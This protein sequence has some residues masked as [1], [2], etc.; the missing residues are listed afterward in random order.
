MLDRYSS[1][2]LAM[3]GQGLGV[4]SLRKYACLN[5]RCP[6]AFKRCPCEVLTI[7]ASTVQTPSFPRQA[8]QLLTAP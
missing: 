4:L 6:L 2:L 3:K 5:T 8:R 7:L 1:E